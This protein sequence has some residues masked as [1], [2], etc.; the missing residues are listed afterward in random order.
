[1][2]KNQ[3]R[4][5]AIGVAASLVF[6]T[7]F[8]FGTVFPTQIVQAE[9]STVELR[10]AAQN[11]IVNAVQG[12]TINFNIILSLADDSATDLNASVTLDTKYYLRKQ[13]TDFSI[14][15][16]TQSNIK[17]NKNILN[18]SVPVSVTVDSN[19][20]TGNISVPI[21]VV[22][23]NDGNK[24]VQVVNKTADYFTVNVTT[25]D[26]TA[27]VVTISSP[28]NNGYYNASTLPVYPVYSVIEANKHTDQVTG[29]DTTEGTHTVTVT[30][31]DASNNIGSASATYTVD[32]TVPTIST[33]ITDGG[34]YNE[35]TLKE[36]GTY[37]SAQDTN[38][39]SVEGTPLN[40]D[41]GSYTATV[42][43]VDKAGNKTT[44]TVNYTVDNTA[45]IITFN[46]NDGGFYKSTF[47][48]F[49][50]YYKVQ[51]AYL[52]D[53]TVTASNLDLS[54]GKHSAAVNA[55][56]LA[57][58]SSSASASYTVDDTAP[59]VTLKLDPSQ[60]YNTA[61]LTAL[62]Q[63]YSAEDTNLLNVDASTLTM[64]KDGTYAAVVI[65][66]DKAGN[67]TVQSVNY[68]VDNTKPVITFDSKLQNGG[69]YQSST[70]KSIEDSFFTASDDH[71]DRVSA[72]E[73][74]S[75]VSE[76][77][78]TEGQHTIYVTAV[79]KAGNTTTE[80]ITYTIDDIAPGI[81]FNITDGSY[82]TPANLAKLLEGKAYYDT[83]DNN[84]V[85]SVVADG[86][87][88]SEGTHI[89]TVTAADAAGN[90][91]TKS[92][93]YIIDNTP[94]KV[95]FLI[96]DGSFLTS[97]SLAKALNSD[98]T[99][100]TASDNYG[101]ASVEADPLQVTEGAYTLKV[102][103]KDAAGN[104]TVGQVTY[105]IDNTAPSVSFNIT[106]GS[107]LTSEKLADILKGKEAYYNTYDLNGVASVNAPDLDTSEG[108]HTLNVI[109]KDKAGNEGRGQVTYTID[110]TPPEISSSLID[111]GIYNE[112][113]LKD[114]G[115]YYTVT[116]TNLNQDSVTASLLEYTEGDHSATITATD[117]AGNSTTKTIKYTVDN[118][119][120]SITF[121][122]KDKGFYQSK[123]L[124]ELNSYYNVS[125]EHLD[126]NSI[127]A[128]N[129]DLTEGEHS[130][131][132]SASDL[133]GNSN[134]LAAS[135]TIDNTAPSVTI[136]LDPSKYYN[137]EALSAIGD[138]YTAFDTNLL[139]VNSSALVMDQDGTYEATVTAV[140]RAGNSTIKSGS[141]NVDNTKPV[142]EFND[143]LKNG[144]FYQS[145]V[146]ESIK[147]SFFTAS[148][149]HLD[150][151]RVSAVE[152]N[153]SISELDLSE[154]QHTISVTAVD[155]AGNKTTATITYTVD[156]TK[157]MVSFTGLKDGQRFIVGQ[158]VT[159]NWTAIDTNLDSSV[160]GSVTLDTET[161]GE[162][163]VTIPSAVDKAGNATPAETIKY[164]V[165]NFSGVLQPIN[166]D[167]KS[168]FKLG[169]TIPV[170]FQLF[171]GSKYLT[172]AKA[173][174]QL[175][176]LSGAAA[177]A[178]N[179]V[180][181][182]SAA[183]DGSLFRYDS[184]DNQYIFNLST[185]NLKEGQYKALII[186][187]VDGTTTTKESVVFIIRK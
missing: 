47:A 88:S 52:D 112:K 114:F 162:K 25:A 147:A 86:L 46:F 66:T 143:L 149:E 100:Y 104:E 41:E 123:V 183:T 170:K 166:A 13:G 157:P 185:K 116:D 180:V 34:I 136:K 78:L 48:G 125:D 33:T 21:I 50:P 20:K 84:A 40:S 128:S 142:V 37:Y 91:T 175:S 85:V 79:D 145:S 94:P 83:S 167:G 126:N 168:S 2:K 75:S 146:L 16:D 26:T 27:P 165:Y 97:E 62:G 45:P 72:V 96:K 160:S 92:I 138:Y 135:Y 8:Q 23:S 24:S 6:S 67:S 178:V 64:D 4:K 9:Q 22:I 118:T 156:N 159:V 74:D 70:L 130:V 132:V 110:N 28:V 56:D 51:D 44:K 148:D 182:T 69:F 82:Y 117:L 19:F 95:S 139:S 101:V 99:Y 169:S 73:N 36:M 32:T 141:Y 111:G 49:N 127:K 152:N 153:S 121:N 58:N 93:T 60:Y 81:S 172:D 177:T 90:T 154:G 122:F 54:E 184:T 134:S 59:T 30:S 181:S 129:F 15:S 39:D 35:A 7:A 105:T 133:A 174:I 43:A 124:E 163:T 113:T 102:I 171:N 107:F 42:T 89:L 65:A 31:T 14:S 151:S 140:D 68:N 150:N 187:T 115:K 57:G 144:G 155:K 98:G 1:M 119:A 5:V 80:S 186:I 87:D 161:A 63:Y 10:A 164:Y 158:S 176:G 38:L 11:S 55:S 106:N 173:T 109:A 103:A 76:L 71:L 18:A 120:P 53:K 77:D 3:K 137:K 131:T 179:E 61:A 17:L 29:W 12:T 108:S